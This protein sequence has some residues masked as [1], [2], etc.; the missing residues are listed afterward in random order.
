MKKAFQRRHVKNDKCFNAS[1]KYDF[2]EK[3][4]RVTMKAVILNVNKM[5]ISDF[6]FPTIL[7]SNTQKCIFKNSL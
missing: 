2:E 5:T 7:A 3:R 4:N 1:G 6:L